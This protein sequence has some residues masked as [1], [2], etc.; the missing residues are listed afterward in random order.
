MVDPN[1]PPHGYVIVI[2]TPPL[3][4]GTP[5]RVGYLV[6][7][8]EAEEALASAPQAQVGETKYV[9]GRIPGPALAALGLS[10]GMNMA[11]RF[12]GH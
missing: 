5:M 8:E 1:A 9:L 3:S 10:R 11:I 12:D 7:L 4:G 2:E 6:A